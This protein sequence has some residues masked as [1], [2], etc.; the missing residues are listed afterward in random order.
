MIYE[1]RRCG[2]PTLSSRHGAMRRERNPGPASNA[3]ARA[4][5]LLRRPDAARAGSVA[6]AAHR[7]EPTTRRAVAPAR[8]DERARVAIFDGGAR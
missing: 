1:K 7:A 2:P 8:V 4:L 5:E 6:H 3:T